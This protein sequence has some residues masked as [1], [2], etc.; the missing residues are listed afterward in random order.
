MSVQG[1][2]LFIYYL[3]VLEDFM[4]E[5]DEKVTSI[6]FLSWGKKRFSDFNEKQMTQ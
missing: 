6:F 5:E 1:N 3:L 4:S 2:A